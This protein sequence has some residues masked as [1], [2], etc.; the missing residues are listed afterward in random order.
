M[1]R[2]SV[3]KCKGKIRFFHADNPFI[4]RLQEFLT[5]KGRFFSCIRQIFAVRKT[6]SE[7]RN[8]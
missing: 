2:Q 7:R 4:D 5:G 6:V 3:A 1:H 8:G